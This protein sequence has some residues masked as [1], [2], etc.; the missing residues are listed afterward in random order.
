MQGL[1]PMVEFWVI[2][3]CSWL[4][5]QFLGFLWA[6][7]KGQ[8]PAVQLATVG[9]VLPLCALQEYKKERKKDKLYTAEVHPNDGAFDD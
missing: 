4:S 5:A 6:K 3:A 2:E 1:T 9:L 7:R 8:E